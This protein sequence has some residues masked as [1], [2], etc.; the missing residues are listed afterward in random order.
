MV[1][2][3]EGEFQMGASVTWQGPIRQVTLS[4]YFIDRDHVTV[5]DYA[6]C[7]E[8]GAC[9][10]AV[11]DSDCNGAVAGREQHPINC[12]DWFQA[13]AYCLWRDKR[14]PTEAEWEKAARGTD[15][16]TFPWGEAT[17]TCERAVMNAGS[18]AGCGSGGTMPVGSKSPAGDSPY[19]ATDM[20]GNVWDWTADWYADS[21]DPT[22]LVDPTGPTAPGQRNTKSQR[23]GDY[24]SGAL[25]FLR[26]TYRVEDPQPT[27]SS[28]YGFRCARTPP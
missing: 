18:G 1:C 12:V 24:L 9:T 15:A 21:Y 27:R 4:T 3:P 26:A 25:P 16:R 6:A 17:P 13:D 11:S 14:L 20:A 28:Y 8:A 23:G 22:E 10:P 2:V 7:L 19:G 5:E